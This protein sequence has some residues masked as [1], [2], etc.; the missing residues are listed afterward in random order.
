MRSDEP[1]VFRHYYRE[2]DDAVWH[3]ALP[4][5]MNLQLAR[6]RAACSLALW[7]R[8]RSL[9]YSPTARILA[10]WR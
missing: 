6:W 4:M 7:R 5:P 2:P 3:A 8:T 1:P 9:V 10:L